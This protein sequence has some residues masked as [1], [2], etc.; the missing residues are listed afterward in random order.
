MRLARSVRPQRVLMAAVVLIAAACAP[1]VAAQKIDVDHVLLIDCSGTMRYQG[2]GEAT[3]QAL[4]AFLDALPVGDRVSVYGYGEEPFSALSEYPVVIDSDRSRDLVKGKLALPF[5]ADRTDIT[6]GLELVWEERA[7]VFP[8]WFSDA[9]SKDS[10]RPSVIL[11]TDGKLIPEYEDYSRYDEIYGKSRAR[12]LELSRL[13]GKAGIPVH[14]IALGSATKVDGDLLAA[15]AKKSGGEYRHSL[16]SAHLKAVFGGLTEL[17]AGGRGTEPAVFDPVGS[18]PL[19]ARA[20]A[21][22]VTASDRSDGSVESEAATRASV[23]ARKRLR[24]TERPVRD[25]PV[26]V[27]PENSPGAA[28]VGAA[29]RDLAETVHQTV[30]GVLGVVMGFVAIGIQRRQ[31][32]THAFTKPLLRKEIRVKG[33]LKPVYPAGIVGARSVIPIENPGLPA[34]EVGVGTE[35][36]TDTDTLIEFVGTTD[37]S[38]PVM[39]I[40]RGRV[41]VAGEEVQEERQLEDGDII[42]I[43]DKTYQYLRG[44]RR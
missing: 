38:P 12:L 17:V 25:E 7:R 22:A 33:Y 27:H 28:A 32:W 1:T 42:E 35:Y 37:G 18:T 24:A 44:S 11:L 39:R 13:F 29:F 14:T 43:E 9:R 23:E 26:E 41:S 16:T 40:L 10:P 21:R 19:A 15:V 3:L 30:I 31:S 34:V 4:G 36:A 20:N 8:S 5:D 2:R 6:R